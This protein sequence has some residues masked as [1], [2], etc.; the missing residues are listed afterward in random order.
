MGQLNS[1]QLME[2]EASATT[3]WARRDFV[4]LMYLLH[5]SGAAIFAVFPLAIDPTQTVTYPRHDWVMFAAPIM[6]IFCLY[7][8]A[9]L[10][11]PIIR[12]RKR[13]GLGLAPDGIYHWTWFGCCFY[14]WEWVTGIRPVGKFGYVVKLAP[15]T[16]PDE[17]SENAEENFAGRSRW[18]RRRVGIRIVVGG[19]NCH[20]ALAYYALH[21]Y[22][23]HPEH[24]EELGTG[25]ATKR[26]RQV[27]FGD[28]SNEIAT[29]GD[30]RANINLPPDSEESGPSLI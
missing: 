28:V 3:I 20:P 18:Y 7:F 13:L 10:M 14:R 9:Y 24:R 30:V 6:P 22:S 26:M 16:E 17:R 5:L 4:A 29:Y 15:W 8:L 21:Y 25:I 1:V 11:S 19:L 23:R 12:R 2:S 27:D